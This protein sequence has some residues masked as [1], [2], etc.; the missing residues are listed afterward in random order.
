[1]FKWTYQQYIE[2][3]VETSRQTGMCEVNIVEMSSLAQI[4]LNEYMY[5]V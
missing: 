1:M 4:S 2:N 5:G 3:A